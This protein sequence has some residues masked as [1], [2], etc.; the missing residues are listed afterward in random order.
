[1][2]TKINALENKESVYIKALYE[3][4]KNLRRDIFV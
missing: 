2:G 1:M 4:S 3:L